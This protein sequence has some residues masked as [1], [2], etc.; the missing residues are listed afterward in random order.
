MQSRI[1]GFLTL[2]YC[3]TYEEFSFFETHKC[4]HK[5]EIDFELSLN[6]QYIKNIRLRTPSIIDFTNIREEFLLKSH[7]KILSHQY[8]RML[9]EVEDY[10]IK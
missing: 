6:K 2:L 7:L 10:G 5:I 4:T 1:L 9:T 3:F 8:I